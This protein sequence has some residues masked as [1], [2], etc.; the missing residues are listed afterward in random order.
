MKKRQ[1]S[2]SIAL[3]LG[4]ST[5]ALT[6]C[7]SDDDSDGPIAE[8]GENSGTVTT[9][10]DASVDG[11]TR[12]VN[13]E[14]LYNPTIN[15]DAE[16]AEEYLNS[17]LGLSGS[18]TPAQAAE[19]DESIMNAMDVSND[20]FKATA[21]V[22]DKVVSSNAYD[23]EVTTADIEAQRLV[24]N[25]LQFNTGTATWEESDHDE[26]PRAMVLLDGR[27]LVVIATDEHN[28]LIVI[29]T[30]DASSPQVISQAL[31]AGVEGPRYTIDA[32]TG[33]SEHGLRDI[34]SAADGQ[35]VYVS[36]KP[37]DGDDSVGNDLDDR[38]GL[39]RVAIGDDGVPADYNDPNS[40]R[41][42]SAYVGAFQVAANGDVYMED[43]DA[44]VIRI[45]DADLNDTGATLG[46]PGDIEAA[47]IF[48]TADATVYIST[49]GDEDATP[50]VAAMLHRID[51]ET[52]TVTASMDIDVAPDGLVL[53][54]DDKQALIYEEHEYAAILDLTT[55]EE[56]RR[57]PL[58]EDLD[59]V[60]QTATVT[61]D[62]HYAILSG[63]HNSEIWVFD[64][65]LPV[66]RM[67]LLVPTET[68][69]RALATDADG[70]IYA[71]GRD[72]FIDISTLL[73]GDI[74]TPPQAV[75][76]DKAF[77]SEE[78]LNSGIP[79]SV[80]V[81]D[82]SLYS[83]VPAGGGST[84]EWSTT[85][86]SINMAPA[87][88][89]IPLGAVTRPAG[90]DES[91][92]LT[93]S[94]T[95]SFRDAVETDSKTFTANIRQAPQDLPVQGAEL[96][97]GP[98]PNGYVQYMDA[99]S[100]GTRAVVGFRGTGGFNVIKRG[101]GDAPE[102]ALTT[103]TDDENS[104]THQSF[105]PPYDNE[106]RPVGIQFLDNSKV[107]IAMPEGEDGEGNKTDGALLIYDVEDA[108]IAGG[109]APLLSTL[110]Q[111]GTVIATS[112]PVN[113]RIAVILDS[114]GGRKAVILNAGDP[115]SVNGE[116]V[117][118]STARAVALSSDAST[119]FVVEEGGVGSYSGAGGEALYLAAKTDDFEPNSIDISDGIVYVGTGDGK[120]YSFN[121]NDLSSAG[122]SFTSGYGGRVQNLDIVGGLAYMSVWNF[123]VTI[124]EP[125][126][127]M[128]IA[129]FP[130]E[131]QRRA[132]V[133]DDGMYIFAAQ[134]IDRSAN[135]IRILKRE[136]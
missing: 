37:E 93:A 27:D 123:G 80:V 69:I 91:G 14:L 23:V 3:I 66:S 32:E 76:K 109:T 22:V 10:P 4:T 92:E 20:P 111:N 48:F 108:A 94:L 112:Q 16:Q 65:T 17:K 135:E 106:I 35:S 79:L 136:N 110:V 129:F 82:L 2:L 62:G 36:V 107:L 78:S 131:R 96:P 130:H 41:Y 127:Q 54:D 6:G 26:D 28:S 9:G 83:E 49:K 114:D 98:F 126:Q 113:G 19:L 118:S 70:G 119:V 64:L 5:I 101:A 104:I 52:G 57:L 105:P 88:E 50:P 125:A 122:D 15:G 31:F 85:T 102:Y 8:D 46:L 43:T 74:L 120:L 30:S 24:K 38:Y 67:E 18:L 132:A 97:G 121:T 90:T 99:S 100:D 116:I 124:V 7:S 134:F 87:T 81:A 71:A 45:L 73:V 84:I 75:A 47:G 42:E 51:G 56:T 53:F 58:S 86:S 33:A 25:D 34:K 60:V 68:V 13:S 95:Y 117:L 63:H 11:F 128:E 40:K 21:A 61:P 89:D 39:F 77:I 72:G 29:D 133:S 1:L 59:Q 12:M 115:A 44:G 103:M 55:M